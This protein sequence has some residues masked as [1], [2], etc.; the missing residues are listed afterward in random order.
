MRGAVSCARMRVTVLCFAAVREAVGAERLEL[1]VAAGTTV[2]ALR[3]D[4]V[5]AHP[6]LARVPVACA[7]NQGYAGPERELRDGDE[8]ALIPPISG[9]APE[10]PR[11]AFTLSQQPLDAR[12]LE[13]EVRTDRDGAVVTFAG[14]TRDH[15]DGAAVRHLAYEAYPDMA[16]AEMERILA[17]AAAEFAIGRVRV[18]HRLG[19]V[20]VGEASVVVVVAAEHRAA[21]FDACRWIMDRL[22]ARVPIFKRETLADGGARW[23][24]DLPADA[25]PL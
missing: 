25:P 19:S 23:V 2:A 16:H 11:T 12:A 17:E 14:V 1:D 18:A 15:H 8:V 7:V 22:K 13:R 20:P 9:G 10:P 4:L 21:A 6:A 3:R 5:A 24:G